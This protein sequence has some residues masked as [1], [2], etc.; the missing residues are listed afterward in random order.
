[1]RRSVTFLAAALIGLSTSLATAQNAPTPVNSE[2]KIAFRLAPSYPELA[3]RMHMHGVVRLEAVVRA[4]G[5]VK[6][7][8]IL[9]G[10]PVLADAAAE[11]VGKWK[12]ATAQS[13][14]TEVV[15]LAFDSQ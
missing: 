11:A 2:R 14:T 15:Q 6:A 5:S 12:F 13:E 9:G 8:R 10:N 7:T 4:N 1:M 3:R